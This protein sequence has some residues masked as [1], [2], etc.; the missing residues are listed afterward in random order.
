MTT[1]EASREVIR[2]WNTFLEDVLVMLRDGPRTGTAL[3]ELL[4][5]KNGDIPRSTVSRALRSLSANGFIRLEGKPVTMAD[6]A[7]ATRSVQAALDAAAKRGHRAADDSSR[8]GSERGP[9]STLE[10]RAY[11]L[12][13]KGRPFAEFIASRRKLERVV[14]I[15]PSLLRSMSRS[16]YEGMLSHSR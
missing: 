16:F 9:E 6:V 8:A 7:R 1:P 3:A 5:R 14:D 15:K 11:E 13:P 12:T 4:R 10:E 2:L